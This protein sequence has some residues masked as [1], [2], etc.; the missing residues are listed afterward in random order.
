M[1]HSCILVYIL[2]KKINLVLLGKELIEK[3]KYPSKYAKGVFRVPL[4]HYGV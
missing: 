3:N 1:I 2:K 4:E